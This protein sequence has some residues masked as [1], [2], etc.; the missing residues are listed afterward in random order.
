MY[1]SFHLSIPGAGS[2]LRI[3]PSSGGLVTTT[4][5]PVPPLV[6]IL[7]LKETSAMTVPSI[8]NP[9]VWLPNASEFLFFVSETTGHPSRSVDQ[10]QHEGTG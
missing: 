10:L 6:Q 5:C 8:L 2:P 9:A 4:L 3:L 7:L 1:V